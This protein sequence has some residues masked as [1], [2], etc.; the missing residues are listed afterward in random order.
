MTAD[1]AHAEAVRTLW[2]TCRHRG[3]S[4]PATRYAAAALLL[5]CAAQLGDRKPYRA[6]A[7]VVAA[8]EFVA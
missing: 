4:L 7:C 6:E 3:E 2:S 1:R 8:S 5:R